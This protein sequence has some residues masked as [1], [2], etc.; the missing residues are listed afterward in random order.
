MRKT[1]S[2]KSIYTVPITQLPQVQTGV[3][4]FFNGGSLH[5][6]DVATCSTMGMVWLY[7][8]LGRGIYPFALD[9]T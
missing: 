7:L 6:A 4:L 5:K 1:R 9:T 8:S 3:E 2:R